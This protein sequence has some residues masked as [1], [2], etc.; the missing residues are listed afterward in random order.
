M[1]DKPALAFRALVALCAVLAIGDFI[2]HRH[3]YFALEAMPLFFVIY[4]LVIAAVAL[5]LA[6]LAHRLLARAPHADGDEPSRGG[7]H[8]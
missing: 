5:V 7:A 1:A 4:G 2:I 3:A 8:D 6:R